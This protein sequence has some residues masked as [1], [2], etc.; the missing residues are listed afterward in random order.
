MNAHSEEKGSGSGLFRCLTPFP[1]ARK[2]GQAPFG[3]QTPFAH[4]LGGRP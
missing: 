2:R 3:S 4:E 1:G